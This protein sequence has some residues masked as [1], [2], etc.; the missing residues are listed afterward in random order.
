MKLSRVREGISLAQEVVGAADHANDNNGRTSRRELVG[1][2]DNEGY[3]GRHPMRLGSLALHR[4][5]RRAAGGQDPGARAIARAGR[6]VFEEIR[7][8]AAKSGR[9]DTLEASEFE[10]L[11]PSAKRLVEF[12]RKYAGGTIDAYFF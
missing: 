8:A 2:C 3:R 9:A 4:E 5:A 6:S 7:R 10:A 12:S 11:G 1:I